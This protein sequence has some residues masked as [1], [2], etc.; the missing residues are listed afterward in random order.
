[1]PGEAQETSF[2]YTI[3]PSLHTLLSYPLPQALDSLVPTTRNRSSSGRS[4]GSS[5]RAALAQTSL[6]GSLF[7]SA[8]TTAI[9]GGGAYL[10]SGVALVDLFFAYS[11]GVAHAKL[12][13]L[14]DKAWSDDATA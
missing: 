3:P 4:T 1:M 10:S 11:P 12:V 7:Q 2:D 6:L 13:N 5:I 9:N 8:D 14:L